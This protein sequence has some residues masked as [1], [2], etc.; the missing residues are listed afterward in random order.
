MTLLSRTD[1]DR[2]KTMELLEEAFG[3]S[4]APS[5]SGLSTVLPRGN[6]LRP[7]EIRGNFQGTPQRVWSNPENALIKTTLTAENDGCNGNPWNINR[8]I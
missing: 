8:T 1:S 7:A 5:T 4:A 6:R 2:K 3:V